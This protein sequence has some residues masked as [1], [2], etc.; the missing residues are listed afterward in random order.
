MVCVGRYLAL[1]QFYS[2][3]FLQ[4][5]TCPVTDIKTEAAS[6]ASAFGQLESK[7]WLHTELKQ[8]KD[9]LEVISQTGLPPTLNAYPCTC[10][11]CHLN[12][13][14]GKVVC[15]ECDL[16]FC[17]YCWHQHDTAHPLVI[18][19]CPTQPT[20]LPPEIRPIA[21]VENEGEQLENE[22][23]AP[24]APNDGV[25]AE[26]FTINGILKARKH[27]GRLQL[28]VRWEGPYRDTWEYP[29]DLNCPVC[30]SVCV[31][32]CLC[33]CVCVCV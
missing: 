20:I 25:T 26:T 4:T 6:I 17:M 27:Q 12:P 21:R 32:V 8:A 11:V 19:R 1:C 14:P 7:S 2:L 31:Y 23:K 18:Y 30:A 33:V 3:T 28:R 29:S 16:T 22:G 9:N 24:E 5:G 13:L 10:I 15:P